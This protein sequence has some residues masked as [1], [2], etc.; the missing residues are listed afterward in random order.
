MHFKDVMIDLFSLKDK[1]AIVT[2]GNG[3][4]GYG[5]SQGFARVGV[6]IVIAARNVHKTAK[7]AESIKRKYGAKVL[8]LEVDV[9]QER[10]VNSM[11]EETLE[12]FGRVDVLVNN[13]RAEEV[14]PIT[15]LDL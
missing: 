1:V 3:G 8:E 2:G 10:L 9:R 14:N 5:I 7:A 15:I 4:L 11:V 12:R 6:K 13:D